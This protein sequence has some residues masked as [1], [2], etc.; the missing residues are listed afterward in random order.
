MYYFYA[1]PWIQNVKYFFIN[2]FF[3]GVTDIKR[4]DNNLRENDLK[5]RKIFFL[6]KV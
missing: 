1:D 5:I 2:I 6:L 3:F 4:K